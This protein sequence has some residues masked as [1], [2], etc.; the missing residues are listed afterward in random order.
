MAHRCCTEATEYPLWTEFGIA[1]KA[2]GYVIDQSDATHPVA[3]NGA[4]DAESALANFDGISYAKGAAVLRQLASYLGDEVFLSGLRRYFDD[5]L[6]GNAE[7]AELVGAW[8]AAGGVDLDQWTKQW[9]QTA[10]LDTLSVR[11]RDDGTAELTRITRED[12]IAD[13]SHAVQVAG[14]GADGSVLRPQRVLVDAE[15]ARVD[16]P[17]EA[18][19]MIADAFD[20]TWAKIRFE[21]GDWQQI[22]NL[23]GRISEPGSRVVVWNSLV[24]QIRDAELDPQA[25]LGMITGQLADETDDVVLSV[26]LR[27]AQRSLIG[28]FSPIA[29]RAG[30]LEEL[31]RLASA[32]LAA[33]EPGSDR[34]LV[35]FRSMIQSSADHDQLDA[36][37]QHRDL[38]EGIDLD[39]ELTWSIVTR[40]CSLVDRPDVID[41]ALAEDRSAA[42][43]AHA[44]RARAA[45]P[46]LQAKRQ[47]YQ[48]LTQPSQLSAYD[49][50]ATAEAMFGDSAEQVALTRDYAVSYFDDI[51][52]TTRFR[53]GWS[54]TRVAALAFPTAVTEPSV[55]A[56]AEAAMIDEN[57]P[58][59][60]RRVITE[61]IDPLRRAIASQARF[62]R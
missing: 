54:L 7:F 60:I 48:I 18:V 15:S 45:L 55:L 42:A 5:H 31:Q 62:A 53:T 11:G 25:G 13:R 4:V 50:Y 8:A 43:A 39:P 26:M 28:L 30:R 52:S 22:S 23:V 61:S 41:Q 10:G 27:F 20:E 36:W 3:G 9:L 58:A 33:A 57:A 24:D 37:R 6:F 56:R 47:A 14:I 34:Q 12:S 40:I 46:T 16:R 38:P 49:V 29:E 21:P 2:W 17:D 51:G 59:A 19:A 44:A 32:V 1:R 35:A